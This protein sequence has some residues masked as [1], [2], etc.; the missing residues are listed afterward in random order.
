LLSSLAPSTTVEHIERDRLFSDIRSTS[1]SLAAAK[2]AT[3]E[4]LLQ[5]MKRT[6]LMNNVAYVDSTNGSVDG[7][8]FY[9]E[10]ALKSNAASVLL[11]HFNIHATHLSLLLER[12]RERNN[13]VPH[14]AFPSDVEQQREKVE[15]ILVTLEPIVD[16][17]LIGRVQVVEWNRWIDL[18]SIPELAYELLLRCF[19]DDA[20]AR[21]FCNAEK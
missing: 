4:A 9:T 2:V 5:S 12:V 15:R 10:L 13:S 16:S 6:L 18:Q 20:F 17:E 7:R 19:V 11:I 3:H 14:P 8:K 1:K 21:N